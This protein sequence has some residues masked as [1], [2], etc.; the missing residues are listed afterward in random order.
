MDIKR[1]AFIEKAKRELER[2]HADKQGDL[3][4]LMKY[5]YANENPKG[6]QELLVDDYMYILSDAL[7]SVIEKKVNR[8]IINI[9]P[10][11]TKTEFVSKYLPLWAL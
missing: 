11:H 7:M 5:V 6:I 10:G 8:L 1:S 4:E 9:P 3:L 2:R